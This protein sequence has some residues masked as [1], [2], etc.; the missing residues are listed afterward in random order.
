MN[1]QVG[2]KAL[3]K[4]SKQEYLLLKRAGALDQESEPHWDI[5][6]GRIESDEHLVDALAREIN[7]ET[8]LTFRET[9]VLLDAQD[10][11]VPT[12]ELHV[13]RLTYTVHGDGTPVLS[14]EHQ[15]MTW[16]TREEALDL[17]LD[18]YLRQVLIK[19]K[20]PE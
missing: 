20:T 15:D 6:G 13:V 12:K 4:N 18:P 19:Q 5:P 9:P 3:V 17:N 7:E 16:A 1:L 14:D 8:G 2:V 10:I 11:F